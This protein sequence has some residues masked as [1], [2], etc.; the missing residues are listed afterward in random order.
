MSATDSNGTGQ[1]QNN[2]DHNQ[3]FR[4]LD[5]PA[6]IQQNV[7]H[8]YLG[9][10][11]VTMIILEEEL[12]SGHDRYNQM[13]IDPIPGVNQLD[14]VCRR[15]KDDFQLAQQQCYSGTVKGTKEGDLF[16]GLARPIRPRIPESLLWLSER[17]TR[18]EASKSGLIVADWGVEF[19][20]L[21][22]ALKWH[23]IRDAFPLLREF[24]Y[25][26]TGHMRE[27]SEPEFVSEEPEEERR[28]VLAEI[29]GFKDGEADDRTIRMWEAY[30]ITEIADALET[31][32]RGCSMYLNVTSKHNL[33]FDYY[34][35]QVNNPF[36]CS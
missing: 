29:E 20:E 4:F 21:K 2:I 36:P 34:Y 23:Y 31:T 9:I 12:V 15:V 32:G 10:F 3:C 28:L 19:F 16:T 24:H 7:Y 8:Q 35:E 25:K 27:N 26:V 18:L 30:N 6:E 22:V 33:S 17:T 11:D 1:T 5:L 14:L 13:S